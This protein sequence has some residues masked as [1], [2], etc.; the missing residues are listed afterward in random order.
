MNMCKNINIEGIKK[1]LSNK[2]LLTVIL[3]CIIILELIIT[4][5]YT[6]KYFVKYG[7]DSDTASDTVYAK[8]LNDTGNLI[9]TKDW[10]PTT[11][12]YVI[13][14]QLIMTPLFS[15][16]DD[17]STVYV[18]TTAIAFILVAVTYYYFMRSFT[19]SKIKALFAVLL[20]CNPINN[21][22]TLYSIV[23]H[24]YLFFV[25]MGTLYI[26]ILF[27]LINKNINLFEKIAFIFIAFLSGICGIRMFLI[28]FVPLIL[29][30]IWNNKEF[31]FNKENVNKILKN[32]K[33][34][35]IVLSYIFAVIG[36]AF[37]YFV[38]SK[39]YGGIHEFGTLGVNNSNIAN[40]IKDLPSIFLS[41][42]GFD[43]TNKK[44]L[45]GAF[46]KAFIILVFWIYVFAKNIILAFKNKKDKYLQ[47]IGLYN[48][49]AMLT[50]LLI[51][52]FTTENTIMQ[53][54][55]RYLGLSIYLFIPVAVLGLEKPNI[56]LKSIF[57]YSIIIVTIIIGLDANID[58]IKQ[59]KHFTNIRTGYTNFL[60]ENEQ[61]TYGAATYWNANITTFL[62]KKKI[63]IKPVI[64]Y[65]NLNLHE[66]NT[67]KSYKDKRPEF[68]ILSINEYEQREEEG[69][70]N[71]IVYE[72]DNFIIIELNED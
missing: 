9:L 53:S 6:D 24:G 31:H 54:S 22:L 35:I 10:Y 8:I 4:V 56:S 44:I 37:F 52:I 40:N 45:S 58:A 50:T 66:W 5:L 26:A 69:L 19:D 14:H 60:D 38:L 33:T 67:K 13:H 42:I 49:A 48:M 12:L 63:E 3:I 32:K 20:I 65:N 43:I 61:Y 57:T 17:Y 25:L 23:F 21:M 11:E 64:S 59:S 29:V 72:D 51:M 71:N 16:F 7:I 15:I 41:T 28:L 2:K 68:F 39:K 47:N 1:L 27:R 55:L 46:I 36:F 70:E 30:F 34:T 62:S 18:I